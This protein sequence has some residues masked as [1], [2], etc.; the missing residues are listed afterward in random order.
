MKV[1][2]III[3]YN[4]RVDLEA[5]LDSIRRLPEAAELEV[6]V[7]DNGSRDGSSEMVRDL[8]PE[9]RLLINERNGGYSQACNLG[10]LATQAPYVMVLNSDIEFD[11]GGPR[12]MAEWM[13]A[14]PRVGAAGPRVLN[15]DGTVQ[16]SCRDFP[17]LPVSLGHAFLGELFPDNPF[18]RS[19]H[20]KD[21]GHD[22]DMGVEW[23]SGA[24]MLLRRTA[25]EE[26]GGFD[27]G[28]FMYVEDVDLCWRL[29]RAGWEIRYYPRVEI[30]H[31]IA[32]SSSQQS[33]RMLY[34]H[35]R[36]MFRFYRRRHAGPAGRLLAPLILSGI[37]A[38]FGFVLALG[39]LRRRCG[40]C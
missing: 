14:H 10:I 36:S 26:V 7:V 18:T 11:R 21:C 8:Y 3:S 25:C 13:E 2:L 9:A 40:K 23:V 27:E 20:M 16:F 19:Y 29:R 12:E 39:R 37:A 15:S 5:A 33:T 6:I 38:R 17:S 4:T 34:Q 32:R 31:H 22:R 30:T 1:A 28:Y 35:H 24:A